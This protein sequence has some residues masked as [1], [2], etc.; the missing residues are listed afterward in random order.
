[1]TETELGAAGGTEAKA[2]GAR[3]DDRQAAQTERPTQARSARQA[4]H[5][6]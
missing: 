2:G 3:D 5:R 6:H 1:M 4:T